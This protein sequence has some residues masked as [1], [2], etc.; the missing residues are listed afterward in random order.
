M[1]EAKYV[2]GFLKS[3][4]YRVCLQV[5]WISYGLS[6]FFP[7]PFQGKGKEKRKRKRKGVYRFLYS[8]ASSSFLSS[9]CI[10]SSVDN[11]HV[12]MVVFSITSSYLH[13]LTLTDCRWQKSFTKLVS[14]VTLVRRLIASLKGPICMLVTFSS[15]DNPKICDWFAQ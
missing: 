10:C 7:S 14:S 13:S 3:A 9:S 4:G 1:I 11:W 12:F 8:G 5:F 2:L 15:I 6:S